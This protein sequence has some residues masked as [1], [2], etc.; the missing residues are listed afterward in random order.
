MSTTDIDSCSFDPETKTLTV[1]YNGGSVW[2]YRE[3]PSKA[4]VDCA[5]AASAMVAIK[6]YIRHNNLVGVKVN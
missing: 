6:D 4:F 1:I 5:N 2:K 3:M